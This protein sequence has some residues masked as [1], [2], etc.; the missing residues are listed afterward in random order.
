LVTFKH[1]DK[2]LIWG[3]RIKTLISFD[4]KTLGLEKTELASDGQDGFEKLT[5]VHYTD[6]SIYICG[7][8]NM[9]TYDTKNDQI[10]SIENK[11]FTDG[12]E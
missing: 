4:P 9:Y 3:D 8:Y 5:S 1:D 11:G 7:D 10:S 6:T 2:F 12:E